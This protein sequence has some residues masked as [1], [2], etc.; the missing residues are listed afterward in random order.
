[1]LTWY[2]IEAKEY[3]YKRTFQEFRHTKVFIITSKKGVLYT[4]INEVEIGWLRKIQKDW[5]FTLT[6]IY[7]QD[8]PSYYTAPCGQMTTTKQHQARCKSCRQLKLNKRLANVKAELLA[9]KVDENGVDTSV[10]NILKLPQ[11]QEFNID[12]MLDLL[13]AKR[14]EAFSL[15]EELDKVIQNIEGVNTIAE[16]IDLITAQKDEFRKG[17]ELFMSKE[18]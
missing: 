17:I 9:T 10:K 4:K 16:Q 7:E 11:I 6:E 1:M 12:G 8:V 3:A 18:N 14:D 15:S 13:K 5:K 2:K